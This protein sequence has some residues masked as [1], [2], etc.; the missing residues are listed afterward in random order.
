MILLASSSGT[1][2]GTTVSPKDSNSFRESSGDRCYI[3]TANLDGE[4]SLKMRTCFAIRQQIGTIKEIDDTLLVVECERP[5]ATLYEFNGFI[6]SPK[7]RECYEQLVKELNAEINAEM[8]YGVSARK[9][10]SYAQQ[11]ASTNPQQLKKFK[12]S[13]S[14]PPGLTIQTVD[15]SDPVSRSSLI[16]IIIRK[17]RRPRRELHKLAKKSAQQIKSIGADHIIQGSRAGSSVR[18]ESQKYVEI[19]LD[20]SNLLPRASRLRNTSFIYGLVIY[21]GKDTRLAHNSQVKAN[22]FSTLENRVN[23]FLIIA[24]MILLTLSLISALG[25]GRPSVGIWKDDVEKVE[26]HKDHS[27]LQLLMAHF[28]IYNYL[29]PISLY[30]TLEFIKFLGTIAVIEDKKFQVMTYK[31][32][33]IAPK[34][35]SQTKKKKVQNN[36][37]VGAQCNS[38]DLNEDLG[39]I[40]VL[41]SDKTGT[42]TENKMRFKACAIGLGLYRLF[43]DRLYQQPDGLCQLVI[44]PIVKK[45]CNL[46]SHRYAALGTNMSGFRSKGQGSRSAS[47]GLKTANNSASSMSSERLN[48]LPPE[49]RPFDHRVI[50]PPE[51][52]ILINDLEKNPQVVEFFMGLCL[53]STITMNDQQEL[54]KCL[55]DKVERYDLR[56]ASPDEESL[57]SAAAL[58]GVIL[59]KSTDRECFIAIRRSKQHSKGRQTSIRKQSGYFKPIVETD[60]STDGYFVR[61][62]ERL[63]TFEFNS[64]RKKMS[65]LYKDCDNNCL[66]LFTKG[67]ENVLDCIKLS[68]LSAENE[69][70]VDKTMAL[71]EAFSKSGLRTMLVAKRQVTQKEYEKVVEEQVEA[72]LMSTIHDREQ[73]LMAISNQVESEMHLIGATAVEDS[74]QEGVPEAIADLRIAGIKVW[75]LTGDKVETA[76]SVAYLCKLLDR[77]MTLLHLVRQQDS[78]SCRDLVITYK[79]YLSS[80][81]EQMQQSKSPLGDLKFPSNMK[82]FI[83]ARRLKK[84]KDNSHKYVD[85]LNEPPKFALISDGRSLHYAMKYAKKDLRY[86]CKQCDCVIG[87]RLSPLQKAEIV[88][89]IKKSESKPICAAIGD[90]ANDVSMIQEAHVGIGIRGKE[91]RQAVN[92]SDFSLNRFYMLNRLLFVHGHLFYHR[93]ANTVLYFFYKNMLFVLPQFIYSFYSA[94]MAASLYHPIMLITYNLVFTSAPI[95]VYG[96]FEIHIS[97]RLLESYPR[98]YTLNKGNSQMSYFVFFTWI[99]SG[100]IQ[101]ALAFYFLYYVEGYSGAGQGS[102]KLLNKISFATILFF[103]VVMTSTVRLYFLAR[104]RGWLFHIASILSCV[105]LPVMFYLCSTLDM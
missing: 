25:I 38:S 11:Q 50:P 59:C 56:S 60:N 97:K 58:F 16:Q 95:L 91:G 92:G 99:I 96:L 43:S 88:D 98:L 1:R 55:P 5:N 84:T 101:A 24:F 82:K 73:Q 54:A 75:L 4:S 19:S 72:R 36:K 62:F 102:D 74:L 64:T 12:S 7:N 8:R 70:I 28:V 2:G 20:I 67:S 15:Q 53:C 68:N 77:S 32:E 21:T 18:S 45:I 35:T 33:S 40:E 10:L 66:I 30:V 86:I 89:M 41:F 23:M 85:M 26:V 63:I 57:I 90:G 48:L 100:A 39:Q 69:M 9:T 31:S 22:K 6:R 3:T 61:H 42:L 65:V 51:Q 52:L 103:V 79:A 87:C 83:T 47:G 81:Q 37:I 76:I 17:I 46:S 13:Q 94:R 104:S 29:V 44:N 93:T 71:F 49:Q 80:M 105:L 34:S 27:I 14:D 78:R